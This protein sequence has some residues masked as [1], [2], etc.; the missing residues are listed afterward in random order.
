VFV[1]DARDGGE[2]VYDPPNSR[3]DVFPITG[4]ITG[5]G[6]VFVLA[7]TRSAGEGVTA[8]S[9]EIGGTLDLSG[10]A[11]VVRLTL[12][13]TLGIGTASGYEIEAILQ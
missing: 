3:D 1:I 2:F 11:P 10:A 9:A 4:T 6:P 13:T 8:A 5:N 12:H 7:G